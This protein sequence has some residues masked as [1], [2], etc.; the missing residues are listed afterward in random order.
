MGQSSAF[1]EG[2]DDVQDSLETGHE[3]GVFN[4][5]LALQCQETVVSRTHSDDRNSSA[6]FT[7]AFSGAFIRRSHQALTVAGMQGAQ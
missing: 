7:G 3:V 5:L 6:S 2:E 4:R 1:G